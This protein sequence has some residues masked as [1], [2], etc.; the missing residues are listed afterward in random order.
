MGLCKRGHSLVE[1]ALP[2]TIGVLVLLGSIATFHTEIVNLFGQTLNSKEGAASITARPYSTQVNP[3]S[4]LA[5]FNQ[6]YAL[7]VLNNLQIKCT[8]STGVCLQTTTASIE[9]SGGVGSKKFM[10]KQL[11]RVLMAFD[12]LL[13]QTNAPSLKAKFRAL[14]DVGYKLAHAQRKLAKAIKKKNQ[15]KIAYWLTQINGGSITYREDNG[16]GTYTLTTV[17]GNQTGS[18]VDQLRQ[19][20]NQIMN[21]PQLATLTGGPEALDAIY[22]VL[23]YDSLSASK[24]VNGSPSTTSGSTILNDLLNGTGSTSGTGQIVQQTTTGSTTSSTTIFNINNVISLVNSDPTL[25]TQLMTL[26]SQESTVQNQVTTASA[27]YG[28]S[29]SDEVEDIIGKAAKT[30]AADSNFTSASPADQESMLKDLLDDWKDGDNPTVDKDVAETLL[31]DVNNGN[32]I[33]SV[34]LS[35]TQLEMDKNALSEQI[36]NAL[37]A[38]SSS[39]DE[40]LVATMVDTATSDTTVISDITSGD[41]T[42]VTT[43][44]E[45]TIATDTA[46][47]TTES[48]AV[49]TQTGSNTSCDTGNG[50][51]TTTG[52]SAATCT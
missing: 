1:Y 22:S 15:A 5:N 21:D 50:T 30:L 41:T 24:L 36:N 34:M 7:S 47:N 3:Q 52:G 9:T 25:Q 11:R 6:Q 40:D 14:A 48:T 49:T 18:L 19:L 8:N 10:D 33:T 31:N 13:D 23:E 17:T 4:V 44:V 27:T 37:I 12:D 29:V 43:A 51:T 35:A 32:S 20:R 2:T 16:D 28:S 26:A 46:T 38:Q 42:S 39:S 45:D